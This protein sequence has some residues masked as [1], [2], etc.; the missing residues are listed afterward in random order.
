MSG[1]PFSL[2]GKTVLVTGASS[3]IGRAVA[4][5]CAKMGAAV[6]ATGRN[7]ERLR[8]LKELMP[9]AA[10]TTVAADITDG[11]SLSALVD[12]GPSWDG[13]VLC[14]GVNRL[15][16]VQMA[17]RKQL[18]TIFETNFFAQVELIR[19]LL[20]KKK[21]NKGASIVAM[22][23][24]GGNAAFSSGQGAYGASKAALLSWIKTAAKELAP[25]G[26]RANCICP[27]HIET[28]MNDHL[29]L[30]DGQLEEYQKTIPLGRFGKAEDVANG[31]VYLL[32]DAA[33][34]VTGTALTIDG[35]TTL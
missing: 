15:C 19:L 10:I 22:S 2:A 27:G 1:N 29:G 8:Q 30:T 11:E 24:I 16:P 33:A 18:D 23:S 28:P 20:K 9:E 34:W 12:A 3:G 4:V 5:E 21:V 13:V 25:R 14:A 17:S 35:G 31:A 32:S 26:I 7:E 6:V